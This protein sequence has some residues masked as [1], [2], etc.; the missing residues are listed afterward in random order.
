MILTKQTWVYD[1][2]SETEAYEIVNNYKSKQDEEGYTVVKSN[3]D[4]K[5]KKDKK[6]DEIID[7]KWIVTVIVS[8]TL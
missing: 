6:T 1:S 4:Y 5:V 3:V 7:E 2:S 8:Y